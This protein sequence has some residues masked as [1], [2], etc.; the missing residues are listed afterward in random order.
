MVSIQQIN[1]E[2]RGGVEREEAMQE[3]VPQSKLE[4]G[5]VGQRS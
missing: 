1:R 3:K 4:I 5:C 2:S